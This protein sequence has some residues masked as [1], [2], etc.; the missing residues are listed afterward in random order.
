[1]RDA[2][3]AVRR[4]GGE[5]RREAR[6]HGRGPGGE[7]PQW[8]GH[9]EGGGC[10]KGEGDGRE[11]GLRVPY[12]RDGDGK[13]GGGGGGRGRSPAVSGAVGLARHPL[14]ARQ[15]R[16]RQRAR[17]HRHSRAGARGLRGA[18][19]V[20]AAVARAAGRAL[21]V[22]KPRQPDTRHRQRVRLHPPPPPPS[23]PPP[24]PPPRNILSRAGR[25][26]RQ[27][28]VRPSPPLPLTPPGAGTRPHAASPAPLP[29]RQACCRA[30][31]AGCG[32]LS[33]SLTT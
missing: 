30:S 7:R 5:W 20:A 12:I 17:A 27:P 15:P 16:P 3:G 18:G 19:A 26:H 9:R 13:E 24:P 21:R 31:A 28:P 32:G 6:R 11:G 14:A 1:M 25:T 10:R 29:A 33:R 2:G 8:V 4:R 22:S 23:P